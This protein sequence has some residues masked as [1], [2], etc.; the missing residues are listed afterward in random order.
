[1]K[2]APA[3]NGSAERAGVRDERGVTEGTERVPG[4][5]NAREMLRWAWR[6]LTS[7]RTALILLLLLALGAVPGSLIPQQG[8][9]S[10]KTSNWKTAHPTLTPIYERLGLFDVYASPWFAA[11]YVMLMVSLIGC[12]LPRLRVYWKGL[13]AQPPAAPRNLSRVTD[14]ASYLTDE[15]PEVVLARAKARLRR[16]YR[17]R[18]DLDATTSDVVSAEKG[19][20]R[21]AGNLLFHLS[22]IIVLVGF[23]MGGLF[24]YKGGVIVLVGP[25]QG[26]TNTAQQYDDLNPGSLFSSSQMDPFTMHIDKFDVQWLNSG[27]RQGMAKGF[28]SEISYC[29]TCDGSDDQSYDLRVNHPLT[30]GSTQLFLIGHGYAPS[31]TVKDKKGD[32]IWSGPQVFLPENQT[33]F[34]FGV[35]KGTNT[36][37]VADQIGLEG[38]FY[39]TFIMDDNGNPATLMGDDLNP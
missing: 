32:V 20:L 34:S 1:V 21:E 8:V 13:R 33:F 15:D 2:N 29:Q 18:K 4:E 38:V 36:P 30:I 12:I 19:Y 22:I 9:D 5:L 26:F 7:M 17:I 39:P 16:R 25:D 28:K 11:I 27:P 24:G 31:I 6:Q 10:L 35:V 37:N 14:S 23:A 3:E